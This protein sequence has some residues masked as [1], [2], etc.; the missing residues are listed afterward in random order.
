MSR[1]L[2]IN[3][4]VQYTGYDTVFTSDD[5]YVRTWSLRKTV[6]SDRSKNNEKKFVKLYTTL[7]DLVNP[8]MINRVTKSHFHKKNCH[9][10]L[11][12]NTLIWEILARLIL[13][14]VRL[15][16]TR[17]KVVLM[18]QKCSSSKHHTTQKW[19]YA[20]FSQICTIFVWSLLIFWKITFLIK[21]LF[22]RHFQEPRIPATWTC[23][24][25]FLVRDLNAPDI[26]IETEILANVIPEDQ[27]PYDDPHLNIFSRKVRKLVIS[28]LNLFLQHSPNLK[29]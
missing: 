7:C 12:I 20:K 22:Y 18:F 17:T 16:P 8:V 1:Y 4:N 29:S 11:A 9:T 27:N 24:T 23:T 5:C 13:A 10:V 15:K 2:F 26:L 19:I 21:R 6:T 14:F 28:I 3:T 25:V